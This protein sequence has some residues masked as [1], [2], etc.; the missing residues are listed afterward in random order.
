MGQ[1]RLSEVNP[2]FIGTRRFNKAETALSASG[3][4]AEILLY[5]ALVFHAVGDK[6]ATLLS[7][8][9]MVVADESFLNYVAEEPDFKNLH[10]N[11]RFDS[12]INP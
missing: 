3:R 8:E 12:L 5:A 9:E 6:E 10:G 11:E 4:D 2:F 1:T 7:L